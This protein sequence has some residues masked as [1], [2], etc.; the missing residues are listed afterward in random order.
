M[1]T[2]SPGS[3]GVEGRGWLGAPRARRL[4]RSANRPGR[5]HAGRSC[6]ALRVRTPP[7]VGGLPRGGVVR[8]A[9]LVIPVALVAIRL[10]RRQRR[11]GASKGVGRGRD[12]LGAGVLRRLGSAIDT[13]GGDVG[14]VARREIRERV[15]TRT[16]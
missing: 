8:Y 12:S 13:I 15:K 2:R 3:A 9:F 10:W 16:F 1:G 6:G 4:H 11:R 5:S 7:A 14:L